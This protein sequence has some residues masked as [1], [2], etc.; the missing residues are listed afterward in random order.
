MNLKED[1]WEY[2]KGILPVVLPETVYF[3]MRIQ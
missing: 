1:Q 3:F 2:K